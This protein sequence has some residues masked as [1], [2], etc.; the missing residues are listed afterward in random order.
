MN[1]KCRRKL[2]ECRAD[3]ISLKVN[4]VFHKCVCPVPITQTSTSPPLT[5]RIRVHQDALTIIVLRVHTITIL[6]LDELE[7]CKKKSMENFKCLKFQ[8]LLRYTRQ[9]RG[10]K[11]LSSQHKKNIFGPERLSAE[12]KK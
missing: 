3:L 11:L 6:I 8:E 12:S 2:Y 5:H 4:I 10:V 7:R 1:E 9:R